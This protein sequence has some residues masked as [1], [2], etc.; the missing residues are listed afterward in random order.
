MTN[1]ASVRVPRKGLYSA[2]ERARRL[3]LNGTIQHGETDVLVTLSGPE[4]LLW[5][6]RWELFGLTEDGHVSS[7]ADLLKLARRAIGTP[8]YREYVST[9]ARGCSR[10][11]AAFGP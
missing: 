2:A 8:K 4:A 10:G 5:Q 1:P 11:G 9:R 7:A 3:S 6:E